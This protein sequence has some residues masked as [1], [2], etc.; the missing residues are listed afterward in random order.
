ML[1]PDGKTIYV[2]KDD[3]DFKFEA[4]EIVLMMEAEERAYVQELSRAY[5]A[6]ET[7]S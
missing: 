2:D 3:I 5:K 1:L 6:G 4:V 7:H